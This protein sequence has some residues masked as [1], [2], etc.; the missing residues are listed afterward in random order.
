MALLP[1]AQV[2]APCGVP[3][4]VEVTPIQIFSAAERL[5]A[6]GQFDQAIAL[7]KAVTK[8]NNPDY[9]AEARVRIARCMLANG[10]RVGAL[11]WYRQLINEKPDA[12]AVR[13]E[14]AQLLASMGDDGAAAQELRRAEANGLPPEVSRIIHDAVEVFRSNKPVGFNISVGVAP[15]TNI[16]N[17]T[18]ADT[19][20]I[21]GIPFQL[22]SN[23][24][25]R[26]GVGLTFDGN[27]IIRRPTS[28][29]TRLIT[30]VTASGRV[31]RDS[32]FNEMTFGFSSGP[33][34]RLS[35]RIT[36]R[37]AFAIGRRIYGS[38]KL[39][40][41]IGYSGLE[42]IS[43]GPKAQFTINQSV[44]R[45]RYASSRREQSG[46]AYSLGMAYDRAFSARFAARVAV[47]FS[48]VTA[49]DTQYAS[50]SL[51]SDVTLSRDFGQWTLFTR[52]ALTGLEGV[53]N[54]SFFGIPRRDR[55]KE[56]GAGLIFRKVSLLGLSPQIR[57]TYSSATSSV[58]LFRYNRL[59]SE[60]SLAKSF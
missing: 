14:V 21:F 47:S 25:A 54:F 50:D 12:S 20:N 29:K 28:G 55:I 39:Y 18:A 15:D 24:R 44:I 51:T 11:Y 42:Q 41:F 56:G 5:A 13:I 3:C 49:I 33:E 37:P 23:G 60:I 30:E 36:V 38:D 57:L 53:S 9:R 46:T 34:L 10:D 1:V 48:H 52:A 17:A 45:F 8:D 31:Y 4:R 22:D 43:A 26:S 6:A 32:Q 2:I 35:P 59:R 58:P 7:L 27:L 40:D 19:V 16:N